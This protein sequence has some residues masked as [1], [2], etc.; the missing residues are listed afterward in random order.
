MLG[1]LRKRLDQQQKDLLNC[2]VFVAGAHVYLIL[3]VL[4]F[5]SSPVLHVVVP[6]AV[7]LSVRYIPAIGKP[8]PQKTAG[9]QRRRV[10]KK[11]TRKKKRPVAKRVH[12]V[13]ELPPTVKKTAVKQEPVAPEPVEHPEPEPI[14][15]DVEL[16]V[17]QEETALVAV[18]HDEFDQLETMREIVS[19]IHAAWVSPAGVKVKQPC[20]LLIEIDHQGTIL[21][22]TLSKSSGVVAYDLAARRAVN[23]M[24]VPRCMFGKKI[25]VQF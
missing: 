10:Q 2:A 24:R 17:A 15:P 3:Y 21:S 13:K 20:E 23:K 16:Q 19:A 12:N 9:R 7:P 22:S 14:T 18:A 6:P 5:S 25:V 1:W 8:V 11:V 4:G